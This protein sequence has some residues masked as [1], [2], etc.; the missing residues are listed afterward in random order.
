MSSS[1]SRQSCTRPHQ[2]QEAYMVADQHLQWLQRDL[3]DLSAGSCRDILEVSS[4][5]PV[6]TQH[7]WKFCSQN[8]QKQRA[9][10]RQTVKHGQSTAEMLK[11][12]RAGWLWV[13]NC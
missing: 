8:H 4:T 5:H 6:N 7:S 2:T 3:G 10:G 11:E 1:S 12:A 9:S 13:E